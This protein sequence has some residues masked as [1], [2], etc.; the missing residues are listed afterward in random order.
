MSATPV[1]T[2]RQPG[3]IRDLLAQLRVHQWVKNV[4]VFVSPL[5]AHVLFEPVV[6]VRTIVVFAAF[7]ACA[8]GV[9]V[10][11]D[12]M[13]LQVDRNHP[14]KRNRP[15]A[16]G[17]LPLSVG[18]IGPLLMLVGVAASFYVS[19]ATMAVVMTYVVVS[20]AYSK[21]LKTQPL[22][23]VFV[24]SVLYTLRVFAGEV[25]AGIEPSVWLLSFSGFMFLSLA[26]L[27]RVSEFRAMLKAKVT[28]ETRR[29]YMPADLEMLKTM[30]V[31]AS[32]IATMVLGLYI[33]TESAAS[34]YGHPIALWSAVPIFLFWQSRMWLSAARGYMTDDPII[35]AAR[36]WVSQLCLALL[37]AVYF[38]ATLL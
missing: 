29:G 22:V 33:S 30:G 25:A 19:V 1:P 5:A 11:N 27:K 38:F 32:Y 36:D 17:R 15:F 6:F 37:L 28:Y 9:Y 35:Y 12:L 14:R 26:F 4:L 20:V 3:L 23:D 7:C 24:L 18:V 2:T 10:V 13:D 31:A 8:S 21:Y 16:S 34:E